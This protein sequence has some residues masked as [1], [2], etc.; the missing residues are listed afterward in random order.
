MFTVNG[1]TFVSD[2]IN[3]LN[4]Q[5]T[6]PTFVIPP[7]LLNEPSLLITAPFIF[8]GVAGGACC[9][10]V[11]LAGQGTVTLLL[12][13]QT[14]GGFTGLFLDNVHY[15]FGETVPGVTFQTEVPEPATMVLLLSG[16]A[17]TVVRLGGRT[18]HRV[19]LDHGGQRR[20]FGGNYAVGLGVFLTMV[21]S[22]AGAA[23]QQSCRRGNYRAGF[24]YSNLEEVSMF[25]EYA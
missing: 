2:V 18:L 12:T 10:A 14:V 23:Q 13:R 20:H 22:V 17:G 16:L 8:T 5:I 7:E 9:Q 3:T 21:A 4:F 24:Q 15:V 25:R 19:P 6:S 11:D 1:Q